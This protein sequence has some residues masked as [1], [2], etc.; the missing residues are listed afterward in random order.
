VCLSVTCGFQRSSIS[1]NCLRPSAGTDQPPKRTPGLAAQDSTGP[2]TAAEGLP[3]PRHHHHPCRHEHFQSHHDRTTP[4]SGDA[5]TAARNADPG[6]S[7]GRIRRTH[8]PTCT[9]DHHIGSPGPLRDCTRYHP[10]GY[11]HLHCITVPCA[12]PFACMRVALRPSLPA[13]TSAPAATFPPPAP[14]SVLEPGVRFQMAM[15]RHAVAT[16]ACQSR[17]VC[18]AH[19]AC[20]WYL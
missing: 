14:E 18:A 15:P 5:T 13:S 2:S 1:G 19:H 6:Q 8:S 7:Q 3:A 4:T 10:K 17:V 11:H 16:A 20:V 9:G 12:D